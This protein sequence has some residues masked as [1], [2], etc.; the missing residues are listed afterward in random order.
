MADDPTTRG[1]APEGLLGM[2]Q[3]P[4]PDMA[5][6]QGG[7][8]YAPQWVLDVWN[9]TPA[10][11]EP[12]AGSDTFRDAAGI[13]TYSSGVPVDPTLSGASTRAKLGPEYNP[14][15][16]G[17]PPMDARGDVIRAPT[18]GFWTM[19]DVIRRQHEMFGGQ[20]PEVLDERPNTYNWHLL[21]N[22]PGNYMTNG[23]LISAAKRYY[24][25]HRPISDPMTAGSF[26]SAPQFGPG[27]FWSTTGE[28]GIPGQL[29][30]Y[31]TMW[32]AGGP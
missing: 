13:L 29:E 14:A 31:T 30:P 25:L 8:N 27:M 4:P 9:R 3:A 2:L 7:Q 23:L 28:L 21:G 24:D 26:R 6:G 16:W 5:Q 32:G 17:P 12:D 22:E 20:M 15:N 10:E 11:V 19:A 18:G 1:G